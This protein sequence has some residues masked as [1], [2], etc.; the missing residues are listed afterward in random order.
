M[1]QIRESTG[2]CGAHAA[3][4]SLHGET[5]G[6]DGWGWSSARARFR[7]QSLAMITLVLSITLRM[8]PRAC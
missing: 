4:G 7:S 8:R 5:Q 1:T 3:S 2:L 6:S